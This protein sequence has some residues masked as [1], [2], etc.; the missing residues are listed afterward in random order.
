MRLTQKALQSLPEGLHGDDS[1]RGLLLRVRGKYRLWLYRRQVNGK[2]YELGLGSAATVSLS[3]ARTEAS[4]LASLLPAEFID[5]VAQRKMPAAPEREI[6]TFHEAC[7]KYADAQIKLGVWEDRHDKAYRTFES[8]LRC[9]VWP[10]IGNMPV[11][12]I[13]PHDIAEMATACWSLTETKDRCISITKVVLDWCRAEGYTEHDNPAAL[14]G[15]LRFLLPRERPATRNR[16]ALAVADLPR[17]FASSMAETQTRSRQCFEFSILTATRSETARKAQWGQ[18]DL[19]KATWTIPATQLKIK[20]NGGL[21]V[22]LATRVVE[23]LRAIDRPHEGLIFP[24]DKGRVLSDAIV[25]RHV[26]I[27]PNSEDPKGWLDAAESLKRGV[28]VRA[29]QHGIARATFMTW[30]QD[31]S[32]GNDKRFDVRVAHMALHH[33]LNDGYNGAYERQSLFQRRRELMEAWAEYCFSL[34]E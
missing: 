9:H 34:V 21:V 26:K 25:S 29:T 18:I 31:D 14:T 10:H 22:P 24:N 7:E 20:A 5:L 6:P 23:F 19:E 15:P 27:T 3:K 28:D 4:R 12:K 11:D 32:L 33:K 30:S 2:R 13:T 8:R 17:F 1:T 16:G